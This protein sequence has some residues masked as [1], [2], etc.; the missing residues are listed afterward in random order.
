MDFTPLL[1]FQTPEA[2]RPAASSWIVGPCTFIMRTWFAPTISMFCVDRSIH[3]S[4]MGRR[5]QKLLRMN[6][7]AIHCAAM[8]AA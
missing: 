7:R 5:G 3:K 1:L 4:F 8:R 6:N 2:G